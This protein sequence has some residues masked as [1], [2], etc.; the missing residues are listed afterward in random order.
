VEVELEGVLDLPDLQGI[1]TAAKGGTGDDT[2]GSTGVAQVTGGDWTY[3]AGLGDIADDLGCTGSQ[4][5]RRNAGDTAF[6]C[7]TA[8]AGGAP[9]DGEYIVSEGHASLSAEVAPSADDQIPSTDSST[10]A[11]WKTLPNGAVS[12]STAGNTFA[13]AGVSNLAGSTSADLRGVLSD[14]EG[15]GPAMFG[16]T[17]AMADGL[18]CTGDQVVKRN[19]GDTAFECGTVSGGSGLTH[20]QVMARLAVGGAY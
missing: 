2:S 4:Q 7:F 9:T 13:Q 11:S 17:P 10:S 8:S 18:S 16:L 15:S 5:V 1:L 14:E 3:D 6:E 19:A 12:Y 20:P